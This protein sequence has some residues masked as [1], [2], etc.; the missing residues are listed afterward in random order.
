VLE[1][2]LLPP[3]L[4]QNFKPR[5]L[6]H[7]SALGSA[8]PQLHPCILQS[9]STSTQKLMPQGQPQPICS[10]YLWEWHVHAHR[11]QV[12]HAGGDDLGCASGRVHPG[13]QVQRRHRQR[14]RL[15]ACIAC[16]LQFGGCSPSRVMHRAEVSTTCAKTLLAEILWP[17]SPWGGSAV[18]ALG[19]ATFTSSLHQLTC[20]WRSLRVGA[21]LPLPDSPH[22][23]HHVLKAGERQGLGCSTLEKRS[24]EHASSHTWR[25]ESAM[26]SGCARRSQQGP[27]MRLLMSNASRLVCP[28]PM[29]LTKLSPA[30]SKGHKSARDYCEPLQSLDALLVNA[31]SASWQHP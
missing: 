20:R 1:A 22:A 15:R 5:E 18:T 4:L 3:V 8:S 27:L 23:S 6:P 31:G 19:P 28:P 26:R 7:H 14:R 21:V 2:A 12:H 29:T 25:L 17:G 16:M 9:V 11:G 30:C 10:C 24:C 13:L